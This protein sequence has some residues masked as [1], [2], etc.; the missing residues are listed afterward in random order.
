MA[1]TSSSASLG[2]AISSPE[3]WCAFLRRDQSRSK[4]STT[5]NN[6]ALA[7]YLSSSGSAAK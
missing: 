1:R 6:V 2:S 5:R 3:S 4:R 7:P